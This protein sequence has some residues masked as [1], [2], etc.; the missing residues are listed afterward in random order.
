MDF[1]STETLIEIIKIVGYLG[2]SC[3]VFAESGLLIGFF[4]PGDSLLFATGIV[5]SQG[6]LNIYF[7]I[8]IIFI[9][10][11]LGDNFGY[12]FGKRFGPRVFNKEKSLFFNKENLEKA[13]VFYRRHGPLTIVLAR[14]MPVI[15]TFVPILAGVGKMN[16]KVFL[17]YNFLGAFLWSMSL[18]PAGFYL[19]SIVPNIDIYILPIVIGIVLFSILPSLVYI[20]KNHL[21]RIKK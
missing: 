11:V 15:R 6:Y 13:K 12:G 19:G 14:F 1:F 4:L 18:V 20:I 9:S 16:Y 3:I 21:K 8:P 5:A 10:A 2:I 17:F 7:L